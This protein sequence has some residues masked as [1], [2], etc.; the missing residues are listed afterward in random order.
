MWQRQSRRDKLNKY[1]WLNLLKSSVVCIC[2]RVCSDGSHFINYIYPAKTASSTHPA[3]TNTLNTVLCSFAQM[4]KLCFQQINCLIYSADLIWLV[5]DFNCLYV[6][7][8]AYDNTTIARQ[9]HQDKR[10]NIC[11]I[12]SKWW[13][14]EIQNLWRNKRQRICRHTVLPHHTMSV[15]M[16]R[17]FEEE[18]NIVFPWNV[19][20]LQ[21]ICFVMYVNCEWKIVCEI[22]DTKII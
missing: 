18:H 15:E 17:H 5:M 1:Y 13:R 2:Y 12:M 7:I 21:M 19:E 14:H 22:L 11:W 10:H 6:W 8:K 16:F 9:T 4:S 20:F 3:N